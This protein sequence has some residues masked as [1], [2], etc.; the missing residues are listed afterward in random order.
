ML[1][2]DFFE[3][4]NNRGSNFNQFLKAVCFG[5]KLGTKKSMWLE[6]SHFKLCPTLCLMA[7]LFPFQSLEVGKDETRPQSPKE[8]P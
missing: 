5:K 7:Y 8:T 3:E 4:V 6:C 2:I 1:E